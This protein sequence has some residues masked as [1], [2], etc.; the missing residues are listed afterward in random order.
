MAIYR[1]GAKVKVQQ[2][3]KRER[4]LVELPLPPPPPDPTAYR[5]AAANLHKP[6]ARRYMRS[7]AIQYRSGFNG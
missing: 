4:T 7:L 1:H 5:I 6:W 2:T 3:V